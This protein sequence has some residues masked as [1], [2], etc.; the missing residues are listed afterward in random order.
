VLWN[1]AGNG[2]LVQNSAVHPDHPDAIAYAGPPGSGSNG[3]INLNPS[4]NDPNLAADE[5]ASFPF[6]FPLTRGP[7]S[8]L[9]W[10]TLVLLHEV[11]HLTGAND[12]G[13][14]ENGVPFDNFIL[15][16]CFGLKA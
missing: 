3:H 12:H 10:Q 16:R 4:F 2:R 14:Y 1:V 13:R 6:A 15:D 5:N 8:N 9:T 11:G 7:L